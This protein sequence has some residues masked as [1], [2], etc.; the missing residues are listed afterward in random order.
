[1][2]NQIPIVGCLLIYLAITV[3][4]IALCESISK[5]TVTPPE[6]WYL[7]DESPYP[8]EGGQYDPQGA[9]LLT[10]EDGV[11]Y[12]FVMIFYEKAPSYTLTASALET[13]A[14]TNFLDFHEEYP[15]DDSGTLTLGGSPAGYA[16][17]YDSETDCNRLEV[18]LVKNSVY[19]SIYAYYDATSED[20]DQVLALLDSISVKESNGM[21]SL[22]IIVAVVAVIAVIA[23]VVIILLRRR[24]KPPKPIAPPPKPQPQPPE[25]RRF[26]ME[27]GNRLPAKGFYCNNCGSTA[28]N[29]G[30]PETKTCHC[31]TVIPATAKFCSACGAKQAP[32]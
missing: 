5:P 6:N 27:C 24:K 2:K 17:G 28:R 19:M 23:V 4:P 25:E 11:D 26:C 8:Q 18:A 29:F 7:T 12:D 20:E 31:G 32:T 13:K 14:T 9:G 3:I 22:L 1:M 10:Y 15:L 30:G 21:S 16:I